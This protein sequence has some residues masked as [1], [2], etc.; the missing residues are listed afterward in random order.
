MKRLTIAA[1]AIAMV[2][3]CAKEESP[4]DIASNTAVQFAQSQ[5]VTRTIGSDW[6]SLDEV[7]VYMY[8]ASQTS[9]DNYALARENVHHIS[10]D[11]GN[12]T[13]SDLIYYP[14]SDM[15][16]FYAYYP[17]ES[18]SDET[19]SINIAKQNVSEGV[20]DQ[21]AVDFMTADITGQK[22][23]TTALTFDFEHRLAMVTFVITHKASLTTL[24]GVEI[25]IDGVNTTADFS[26]FTGLMDSST[27][28]TPGSIDF[29][30]AETTIDANDNVT[31]LTATAILLPEQIGTSALITFK[32]SDTKSHTASFPVAAS[33]SPG[34]NHTYNISIGYDMATFGAATVTGW[35]VIPS[36]G[37]LDAEESSVN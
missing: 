13:T 35:D 5:I 30:T 16:D 2:A 32:V 24:R 28:A 27:T 31:K 11:G 26:K 1:L 6:E 12:F 10:D 36:T 25:S 34:N 20:F 33:L 17:W 21:G 22:K 4:G 8:K 29:E 18:D 37:A 23:S 15:V 9:V 3:S 19:Y 14:Q 7:G